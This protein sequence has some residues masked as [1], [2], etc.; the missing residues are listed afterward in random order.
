MDELKVRYGVQLPEGSADDDGV[1]AP[2]E[3]TFAEF[4]KSVEICEFYDTLDKEGTIDMYCAAR[5][6]EEKHKPNQLYF[7]LTG[8]H[9]LGHVFLMREGKGRERLRL[10]EVAHCLSQKMGVLP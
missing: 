6:D 7:K 4:T 10:E 9:M 5:P 1:D 2:F 3:T 8:N